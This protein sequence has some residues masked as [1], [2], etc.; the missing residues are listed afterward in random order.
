MKNKNKII[1]IIILIILLAILF[2]FF[3]CSKKEESIIDAKP[4][5]AYTEQGSTTL[6]EGPISLKIWDNNAEDGDTVKVYVDDQLLRDTI[7]LRNQPLDL[8]LGKLD[9]GEHVLG[10]VAISEGTTSPASASMSLD[11]GKE[12]KEFEM[13][14]TIEK[15]S[16][17][18]ILIK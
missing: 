9:K 1:S 5:I 13:D 6:E 15:P 8:D 11:N 18:K 4:K 7:A 10:V 12:K 2:Y 3:K 16:S 14:A 17:W